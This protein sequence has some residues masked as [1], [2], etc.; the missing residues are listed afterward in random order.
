MAT[1]PVTRCGVGLCGAQACEEVER[2]NQI[3]GLWD[4]KSQEAQCHETVILEAVRPLKLS[5]GCV[6]RGGSGGKV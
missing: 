5:E 4:P 6:C 3:I 2:R 1:Q